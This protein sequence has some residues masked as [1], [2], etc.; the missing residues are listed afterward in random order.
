MKINVQR[1]KKG[2]PKEDKIS[3]IL[4]TIYLISLFF[5]W[6]LPYYIRLIEVNPINIPVE[7]VLGWIVTLVAII[8]TLTLTA[9]QLASGA[10][11]YKIVSLYR[12]EPY[13]WILLIIFLLTI[14]V[15]ILIEMFDIKDSR[16]ILSFHSTA[17]FSIL[18]LFP[19]FLNTLNSIGFEAN[20][21]RLINQVKRE[22][23]IPLL[24]ET[25]T[26][27]NPNI[28]DPTFDVRSILEKAIKENDLQAFGFVLNKFTF[29]YGEILQE[30][31]EDPVKFN[32]KFG[33]TYWDRHIGQ[34]ASQRIWT[35]TATRNLAEIWFFHMQAIQKAASN[36]ESMMIEFASIINNFSISS[37]K[38]LLPQNDITPLDVF[39]QKTRYLLTTMAKDGINA[40]QL[41]SVAQCIDSET[42]GCYGAQNNMRDVAF[43]C[44]KDL[45]KIQTIVFNNFIKFDNFDCSFVLGRLLNAHKEIIINQMN[46]QEWEIHEDSFKKPLEIS[47]II[48]VLGLPFG[49]EFSIRGI[50]VPIL[51][52][53]YGNGN[54]EKLKKIYITLNDIFPINVELIF[55]SSKVTL[56]RYQRS[57]QKLSHSYQHLLPRDWLFL[58]IKSIDSI[59]TEIIKSK[60]R[61][62]PEEIIQI[63][64]D[65]AVIAYR[66]EDYI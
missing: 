2:I 45:E 35:S 21:D 59:I 60:N 3:L 58:I 6:I 5:I 38:Y 53:Y 55:Q 13:F 8:P 29:A 7:T 48:F 44:K 30:L 19:Y 63:Y 57:G 16:I 9:A 28:K 64:E 54:E 52:Q 32:P 10:Y 15:G 66:M 65:L 17:L 46:F 4:L 24:F 36:N 49:A 26:S 47:K 56:D 50:L 61:G 22:K 25:K 43:S 11:T 20:V 18:F 31:I 14:L 51:L 42:Q 23:L 39:G 1:W 33:P 40:K 27:L 41:D 37:Y 62:R 12:K 34:E